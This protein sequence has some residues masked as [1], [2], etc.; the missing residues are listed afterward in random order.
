MNADTNDLIRAAFER[1]AAADP[2][3]DGGGVADA[4]RSAASKAD[5]LERVEAK[6]TTSLAGN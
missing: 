3:T 1:A 6:A 2:A 5:K 4:V